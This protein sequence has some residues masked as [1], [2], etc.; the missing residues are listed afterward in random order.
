MKIAICLSCFNGQEYLSQQ[1]DS[2]LVQSVTDWQL[3][4][5][6]DGSSDNSPL[7]IKEYE[8]MDSRIHFVNSDNTGPSKETLHLLKQADK[9]HLSPKKIKAIRIH[10]SFYELTKSVN[11]DFYF[12]SDQDDIWKKN[13]LSLFLAVADKKNQNV[14]AMY[15]SD[16]SVV[17]NDLNVIKESM[18][19]E[20]QTLLENLVGNEVIGCATM[21]NKALAD[22]WIYDYNG[23]YNSLHDSY[24][25]LLSLSIGELIFIRESTVYYRQHENNVIGDKKKSN[26]AADF[27]DMIINSQ[28]RADYIS[29]SFSTSS[30]LD[31]TNHNTL[32]DFANLSKKS[33]KQRYKLLT[34]YPYK[35]SSK[36]QT[37]LLRLLLLSNIFKPS[38]ALKN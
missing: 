9:D 36:V 15:Y 1:I 24:L 17:A 10:R 21:F 33:F 26:W 29:K 20:G 3:F 31:A 25:A 38:T 4:I 27:W 23:L 8:K 19:Q 22:N 5:R 30:L 11:A 37:T 13:K 16:L 6:D 28:T 2:I 32:E 34:E 35:R 12:F 7:I 14:P 18:H